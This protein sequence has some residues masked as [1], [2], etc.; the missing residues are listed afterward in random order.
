MGH[1]AFLRAGSIGRGR[2]RRDSVHLT[3][4]W[5]PQPGGYV[6]ISGRAPATTG[7]ASHVARAHLPHAEHAG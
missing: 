2:R 1:R 4:R 3:T 5:C 6:S 7:P